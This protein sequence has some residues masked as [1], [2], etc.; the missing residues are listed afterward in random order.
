MTMISRIAILLLLVANTW[1]GITKIGGFLGRHRGEQSLN[2]AELDAALE[3]LREGTWWQPDEASAYITLSR[4]VQ[5]AQANGLPLEAL[6]GRRPEG[7]FQY[8][9]ESIERAVELNPADAWAWFH[10]GNLYQGY[11]SARVRLDMLRR[12]VELRARRQAQQGEPEQPEES[13]QSAPGLGPEDGMSVAAVLKA[14]ELEPD[15]YFYDDFLAKIYWE[16]GLTA[17]AAD[18]IRDSMAMWPRFDSHAV[19][20]NKKMLTEMAGPVLEGIEKA[21]NDE[22]L[23]PVMSARARAAVYEQLG[24][25]P[26]ALE[27]YEELRRLGGADLEAECSLSLGKLEQRQ[28]RFRESIPYLEAA[29]ATG[30]DNSYAVTALYYLGQAHGMIGEHRKGADFY[31]EYLELRPGSLQGYLALAGEVNA[32]G[33]PDQAEAILVSAVRR[34][35]KDPTPYQK[36]IQHM[37][38]N[39]RAAR[40]RSYAVALGKLD[41]G[42]EATDRLL[43]QVDEALAAGAP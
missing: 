9:L 31:R 37:L 14:E 4:V 41:P 42:D 11:R 43:R 24:R 28:G 27:A 8:G 3:R 25:I 23:G 20:Q 40:A 1:S 18:R 26:E 36:V 13:P 21:S 33:Q 22:F 10:L 29:A 38:R 39:G 6:A 7:V 2:V 35:P 16:R 30:P 17:E 19:L 12:V 32:L 15:F 34:F 5:Q